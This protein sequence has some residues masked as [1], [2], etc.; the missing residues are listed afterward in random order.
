MLTGPGVVGILFIIFILI[1]LR[2]IIA[3]YDEEEY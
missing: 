3:H 1:L 2:I